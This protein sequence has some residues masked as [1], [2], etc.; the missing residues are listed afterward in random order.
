MRWFDGEPFER[1]VALLTAVVVVATACVAYLEGRASSRAN[2]AERQAQQIALEG[3]GFQARQ[4]IQLAFEQQDILRTWDRYYALGLDAEISG[5]EPLVDAYTVAEARVMALS[6]VLQPPYY[7]EETGDLDLVGHEADLLVEQSA[8]MTAQFENLSN[9]EDG[10]DAK[11]QSY[12]AQLTVLAVG[13]FLFSLSNT[14]P[15][16]TRWGFVGL[17]LILTLGTLAAT[18]QTIRQEV[19][20]MAES[21]LEQYAEAEVLAHREEYEDALAI[22]DAV[23]EAEPD[24]VRGLIGRAAVL[25]ELV[26][27]D[28]AIADYE[29]V[30][31]LGRGTPQVLSDLRYTYYENGD[32]DLSLALAEDGVTRSLADPLDFFDLGLVR[33]SLGDEAGALEAYGQGINL[34]TD[35]VMTAKIQEEAVPTAIWDA[36]EFA[37]IDIEAMEL[38]ATEDICFGAL[39]AEDYAGATLD[40]G[41]EIDVWLRE[42]L[43]SLQFDALPPEQPSERVIQTLAAKDT[44]GGVAQSVFTDPEISGFLLDV[45]SVDLSA[46][47]TVVVKVFVDGEEDPT[48]REV[49]STV[50]A[51]GDYIYLGLGEDSN[52]VLFTGEY[53]VDLYL[54]NQLVGQ[55]LFEIVE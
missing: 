16:Q 34:A 39:Y 2:I 26:Y 23:L 38:C 10:W 51:T 40:V 8:L 35:V 55:A 31:A 53:V 5:D 29:H 21:V 37:T 52:F 24:Y 50:G 11:S 47:E 18:V 48:L 36:L 33:L 6:G 14:I 44:E 49:I 25:D 13:L 7:D 20:F 17:A 43:V 54:D 4:E 41:N 15:G 12:V 45:S 27:L 1:V 30:I 28:D 42:S 46:G 19:P 32:F 9:L 22:Y 3:M